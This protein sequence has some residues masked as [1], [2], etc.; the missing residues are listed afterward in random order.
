MIEIYGKEQCPYCDMAKSLCESKGVEY[1]YLQFGVDFDRNT[2][3]EKFPGARTFPQI[4][5]MGQPIGGYNE[6]KAQFE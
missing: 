6:L 1:T 4:I 2:L 5:F 3:F